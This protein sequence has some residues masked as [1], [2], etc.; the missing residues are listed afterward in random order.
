MQPW[1]LQITGKDRII[2]GNDI[3]QLIH[4]IAQISKPYLERTTL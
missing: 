2:E 4:A 1:Q 3:L